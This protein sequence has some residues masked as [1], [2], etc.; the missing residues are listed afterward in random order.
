MYLMF[1]CVDSLRTGTYLPLALLS[2]RQREV[3]DL[4]VLGQLHVLQDNEWPVHPGD[5]SVLHARLNVVVAD[6]GSRRRIEGSHDVRHPF[7]P[8]FLFVRF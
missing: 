1:R 6:D 7:T 5:R 4:S 3:H 2:R 8:T